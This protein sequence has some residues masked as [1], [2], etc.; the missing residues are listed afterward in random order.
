MP[1]RTDTVKNSESA[2][3]D[4]QKARD[5]RN[6][7]AIRD[8]L[9]CRRTTAPPTCQRI[10][11]RLN[12]SGRTIITKGAVLQERHKERIKHTTTPSVPWRKLFSSPRRLHERPN[13]IA[14]LLVLVL[15]V[16][17]KELIARWFL[18]NALGHFVPRSRL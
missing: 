11:A 4:P 16:K 7:P 2:E 9:E 15:L 5:G 6:I 17:E 13:K 3:E 14:K 18:Q 1:S 8:P 12:R 10:A